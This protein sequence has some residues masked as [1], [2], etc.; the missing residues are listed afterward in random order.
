M[1]ER[2][3]TRLPPPSRGNIPICVRVIPL[4]RLGLVFA[5]AAI[6]GC[7]HASS[8]VAASA[9]VAAAS[10]SP[11]SE[12][13]AKS[14]MPDGVVIATRSVGEVTMTVAGKRTAL[15]AHQTVL[16]RATIETSA[17]SSVVLAFSNGAQIYLGA[18]SALVIAQFSQGAFDGAFAVGRAV[19]EPSTSVTRLL[20][21]RGEL[22]G[23]VKQLNRAGG[24]TFQ[25]E[26]RVGSVQPTD[27]S[28]TQ[29]SAAAA[30]VS[31]QATAPIRAVVVKTM[32][33][34]TK[35]FEG[36]GSHAVFRIVF[37]PGGAGAALFQLSTAIGAA[38]LSSGSQPGVVV[39][40]GR[41]IAIYVAVTP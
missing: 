16:S 7:Q 6:T 22:V 39:S 12:G 24:S 26:T 28:V 15:S 9:P 31:S 33:S 34:A 4:H 21:Q 5:A 20:L 32:Q 8:A 36:G 14:V 13:P 30:G 11:M 37:R 23:R 10:S 1:T 35:D 19:V 27:S 29:S 17:N 2:Q 3:T 41:E 18:E 40:E 25:I 38:E